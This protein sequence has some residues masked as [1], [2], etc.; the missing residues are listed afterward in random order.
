MNQKACV[1]CN[2]NCLFENEGLTDVTGSHIPSKCG[3][4]FEMVPDGV[5]ITADH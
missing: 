2:F 4:I 5:V 1:N 3:N